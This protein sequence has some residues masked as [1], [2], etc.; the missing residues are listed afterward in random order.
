MYM[1]KR[2][3]ALLLLILLITGVCFAQQVGEGGSPGDPDPNN[4]GVDKAQQSLKEISVVKF[5]DPAFFY[6]AM[7]R[8]Q[9][10]VLTR[11][12]V[13]SPID[14]EPIADEEAIGLEE[15]D[16]YVLGVK[17][18]YEKR[19]VNSFAVM[20]VKPLPIA[21]ITKT[22][23][24]WVAGRNN[25]HM[26]SMMILDY[27]GNP[28][29]LTIGKLNFSGWKKLTVAVPPSIT[30]KDYHYTN[31]NGIKFAGFRVDCDPED[32]FGTYYVYF[33]DLRA[34]SDLFTEESRDVDDMA[35]GW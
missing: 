23:S 25:N 21:G 29:E 1:L 3:A 30:Q 20:P 16:K 7:P 9:G 33:D 15:D 35:D 8:D 24:V 2:S 14:K 10:F 28:M 19:G 32:T 17:V 6:T 13:G 5:E 27:F 11:R 22:M 4:I 31:I 26:L 34:V 12:L 18:H